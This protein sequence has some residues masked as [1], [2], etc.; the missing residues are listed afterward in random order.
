MPRARFEPTTPA[1]KRPQTY[2]L[3]RAATGIGGEK[4]KCIQNFSRKMW[5]EETALETHANLGDGTETGREGLNR[6][7]ETWRR[8]QWRDLVNTAINI[9]VL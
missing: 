9:C 6:V 7:H 2:A 4:Q 5:R 8:V 1:T 3:D